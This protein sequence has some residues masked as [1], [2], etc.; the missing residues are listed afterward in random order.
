MDLHL[1]KHPTINELNTYIKGDGKIVNKN[2]F[3][4]LGFKDDIPVL[5]P[6]E[7]RLKN[8][9]P[10]RIIKKFPHKL[11]LPS[12]SSKFQID[13]SGEKYINLNGQKLKVV[14]QGKIPEEVRKRTMLLKHQM[15]NIGSLKNPLKVRVISSATQINGVETLQLVKQPQIQDKL[16]HITVD[17]SNKL[18]GMKKLKL[19]STKVLKPTSN[20]AVI[21][22]DPDISSHTTF[23]VNPKLVSVNLNKGDTSPDVFNSRSVPLLN[24]GKPREKLLTKN[25]LKVLNQVKMQALNLSKKKQET[26]QI[27]LSP[28]LMVVQHI[29]V[30]T[31]DDLSKS[32][33]FSDQVVQTDIQ[34]NCQENI[35]ELFDFDLF[36]FL[37]SGDSPVL[38]NVNF[39]SGPRIGKIISD[40]NSEGGSQLTYGASGK[41]I[42]HSVGSKQDEKMKRQLLFFND[43]R[44]CLSPNINGNLLIH[45]GVV[46]NDVGL[47]KRMCIALKARRAGVNLE[48]HNGCTPLQ[49]AII[50]NAFEEIVHTLLDAGADITEVDGEGNN[51]LHLCA[52]FERHNIL[53]AILEH[54]VMRQNLSCINSFNFDGLTPL[55]MCC[56][57][58]WTDGAVLFIQFGANVNLRDQTSG[59][60]ALFHAAEAMNV[61]IVRLLLD[62][63]AD[64]KI[65]NFFGTSPHDAMYELEDMP[66]KIKNLIFGKTKKRTFEAEMNPVR[67][68]KAA[69]SLKTFSKLQKIE[70]KDGVI[71]S[72]PGSFKVSREVK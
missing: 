16:R 9:S 46:N 27:K 5:Q 53:D 29:A 21:H 42:G 33:N 15:I 62:H 58:S 36:N 19:I 14:P 47:V 48:N 18:Q 8:F 65:K 59:R 44:E 3:A 49:L 38:N 60:T 32:K 61:N 72:V 28:D 54:P 71:V 30:Q 37:D 24:V 7:K 31:D 41:S 52:R 20:D 4:L 6:L 67:T 1:A 12:S 40:N 70:C 50:N 43:L 63:K 57:S 11:T 39:G 56:M 35:S 68:A 26:K 25:N 17:K 51:I 23:S 45:E 69:K 66:D 13:E 64:P 10:V 22:T 55:M 34:R 2:N